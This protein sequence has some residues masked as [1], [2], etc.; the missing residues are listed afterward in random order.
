MIKKNTQIIIQKELFSDELWATFI[1]TLCF[2]LSRISAEH[3][4]PTGRK[5]LRC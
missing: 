5:L 3:I 4:T 1:F 2:A